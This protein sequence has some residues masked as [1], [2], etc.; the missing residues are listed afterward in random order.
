[1]KERRETVGALG[2]KLKIDIIWGRTHRTS[3][4]CFYSFCRCLP[5]SI[6]FIITKIK[7]VN[8]ITRHDCWIYSVLEEGEIH[9]HSD[10][11][12]DDNT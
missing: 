6:G 10:V 7:V 8:V 1:M 2:V 3:F 4:F 11:I 12:F 9:I 5:K